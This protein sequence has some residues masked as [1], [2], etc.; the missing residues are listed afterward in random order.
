MEGFGLGAGLIIAIGAQNAFVL[1]QGLLR[2]RVFITALLCS[3][4]DVLLISAGVAGFGAAI[5]GRPILLQAAAGGGALF[6]F[7]YGLRSFASAWRPGT[8]GAVAVDEAAGASLRSTILALLAFS[9]LNPHVYL[10]T[11]VLLGGLGGRHPPAERLAFAAGACSASFAWFFSL[12]YGARVLSPLFNRPA[13]WRVLDLVIGGVMWFIAW[14][15]L[16]IVLGMD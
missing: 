5:S 7:L 15:L 14:G 3:L 1:R 16:K 2:R 10:D 6:L 4:I 12:A 8:L 9:L 11:V 13:A